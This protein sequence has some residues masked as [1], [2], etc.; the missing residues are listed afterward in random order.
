MMLLTGRAKYMMVGFIDSYWSV[1]IDRSQPTKEVNPEISL[2]SMKTS[3]KM[4]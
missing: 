1:S 3:A 4:G 2:H